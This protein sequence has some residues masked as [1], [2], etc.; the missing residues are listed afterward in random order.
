MRPIPPDFAARLG[1]ATTLCRCWR[2]L[3]RDGSRL[4]FTDHDRD[5]TFDGLLHAAGTGLDAGEAETSLGFAAGSV[6]LSGALS[7]DAI[8]EA[9]LAAGRFDDASLETWLVDWSQPQARLL[10]DVG[11]LGEVRRMD[12]A[13]AVEVRSLA[14]LFDQATGR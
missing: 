5:L 8:S 4:G 11:V 9:A 14:T 2:L 3:M 7:D 1:S 6:E 12:A 10:L 13:F